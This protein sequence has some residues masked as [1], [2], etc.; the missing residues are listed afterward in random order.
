[1]ERGQGD[2]VEHGGG[3]ERKVEVERCVRR[4]VSEWGGCAE[5]ARWTG[6]GGVCVGG[7]EIHAGW[8]YVR[9]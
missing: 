9:V 6:V 4:G 7:L 8:R 3:G 1:M 2:G 5:C